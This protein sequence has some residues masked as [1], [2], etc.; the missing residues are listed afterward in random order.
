[1]APKQSANA[2][3]GVQADF[4]RLNPRYLQITLRVN[5]DHG[6]LVAHLEQYQLLLC[7]NERLAA[8]SRFIADRRRSRFAGSQERKGVL[9]LRGREHAEEFQR[10]LC[11]EAGSEERA[12][13]E[14]RLAAET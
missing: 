5:L 9:G 2:I 13:T 6:A 8:V 10:N 14:P 11:L 1:L 4:R 3:L 7:S 12:F